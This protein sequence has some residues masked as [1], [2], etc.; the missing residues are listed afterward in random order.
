M[1]IDELHADGAAAQGFEPQCACAC[2][3][4]EHAPSLRRRRV[5]VIAVGEQ[6]EKRLAHPVGSGPEMRR[7]A[8]RL[9]RRGQLLSPEPS[10][11]DAHRASPHRRLRGH[12]SS[13]LPQP[14]EKRKAGP[15]RG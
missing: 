15:E 11:Y 4:I 1:V 14:D 9:A 3:E 6:V 2:K 10:A 13:R 12:I 7:A 5:A 8:A